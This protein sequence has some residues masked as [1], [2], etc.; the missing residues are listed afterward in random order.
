[1]VRYI[2]MMAGKLDLHSDWTMS[3]G[4]ILAD[5]TYIRMVPSAGPWSCSSEKPTAHIVAMLSVRVDSSQV[6]ACVDLVARSVH[7]A[8]AGFLVKVQMQ[9]SV[10]TAGT[11][12]V[13]PSPVERTRMGNSIRWYMDCEVGVDPFQT[14]CV[15]R[16]AETPVQQAVAAI[17]VKIE[18]VPAE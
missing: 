3:A 14:I 16:M 10:P 8:A 12:A 13:P 7:E 2:E 4:H 11:T 17:D 15:L 18:V 6:V 5:T 1:M 9:V